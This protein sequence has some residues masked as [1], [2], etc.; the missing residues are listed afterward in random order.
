MGFQ[1]LQAY[2]FDHTSMD[3]HSRASQIHNVHQKRGAFEEGG[4]NVQR[5]VF[6]F[7]AQSSIFPCQRFTYKNEKEVNKVTLRY[8]PELDFCYRECAATLELFCFYVHR[9]H[10]PRFAES[11][12]QNLSLVVGRIVRSK[13]LQKMCH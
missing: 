3:R 1:N 6:S 12:V 4:G 13:L 2:N 10:H 11:W 8:S 5:Q 7:L 9:E